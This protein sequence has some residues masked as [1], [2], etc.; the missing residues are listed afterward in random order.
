MIRGIKKGVERF[1]LFTE[2]NIKRVY[3]DALQAAISPKGYIENLN[4]NPQKEQP[5]EQSIKKGQ[6][7]KNG[8][9]R[10]GM[11]EVISWI[12]PL[13][14]NSKLEAWSMSN[15]ALFSRFNW[16]YSLAFSSMT[17]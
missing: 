17:P 7:F 10:F 11:G 8:M 3:Q 16:R 9:K 14:S 6:S 4:Q 1:S 5:K 13:N 12:A 15:G 2:R